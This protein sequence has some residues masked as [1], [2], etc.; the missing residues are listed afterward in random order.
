MKV[1]LVHGLSRS[2]LSFLSL[3]WRLEALGWQTELFGY[4]AFLESFDAIAARLRDRLQTLREGEPYAIVAHSLGGLLTRAALAADH[5]PQP[6]HVVMLGTPNQ[7]P[8]LAPLAWRL[9][10]FRWVT[11]SCGFNLTQAHFFEQLPPLRSPYTLIAGVGGPRG[12]L[13]PFGEEANDGIVAL[14]ETRLRESDRP[15]QLPV[16]HT[17]MMN[18]PDVQAV[19]L[20]TLRQTLVAGARES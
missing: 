20:H 4:A 16:G 1:L 9:W 17:F 14:A 15:I 12:R 19:V 18:H 13:S 8:R 11:G 3:A 10:P 5:L 7:R 2:P 6:R